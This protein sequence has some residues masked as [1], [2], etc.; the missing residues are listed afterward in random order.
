[1]IISNSSDL[2]KVLGVAAKNMLEEMQRKVYDIIQKSIQEYYNEYTP[3]KYGRTYKFLKSLIKTKIVQKGNTF[4]CVVKISDDY[5]DYKY[6]ISEMEREAGVKPTTGLD[7][8]NSAE[9]NA[10]DKDG[11]KYSPSHGGVVLQNP[12][13]FWT[14]GIDEIND[15]EFIEICKL[16]RTNLI[17]SGFKVK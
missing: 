10:V 6:P 13:P 2:Q 9:G 16:I 5:L 12:R 17:R 7:V 4:E 15:M 8:V 11:N 14:A 3:K 1:M